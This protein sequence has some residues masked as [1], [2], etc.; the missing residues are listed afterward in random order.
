M[1]TLKFSRM[2]TLTPVNPT[3]YITKNFPG[4][5]NYP[6]SRFVCTY[7]TMSQPEKILPVTVTSELTLTPL[8]GALLVNEILKGLLYQKCQIPYSYTYMKQ[9]VEKRRK[10]LCQQENE[11]QKVNLTVEKHYRVVSAAYDYMEMVMK[12]ISVQFSDPSSHIKEVVIMFGTSPNF[13]TEVFTI[14]M[15]LVMTGH[16]ECNHIRQ[17]NNHLHKIMRDIFLSQVWIDSIDGAMTCTNTFIFLKKLAHMETAFTNEA[18]E[19]C[20]PIRTDPSSKHVRFIINHTPRDKTNCCAD[21]E[22]FED[23][24]SSKTHQAA[25]ATPEETQVV[26][27]RSKG[28]FQGFRDCFIKKVSASESW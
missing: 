5:L 3:S 20:A 24:G 16:I 9:L 7:I 13:P 25:Q 23:N 15:P 1:P 22:I 12:G 11:P 14:E 19:A 2:P 27:C 6:A 28:F 4:F 26:W 8:G 17:L 21:L 10:K 18:F